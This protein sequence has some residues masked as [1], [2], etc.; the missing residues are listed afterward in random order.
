MSKLD[1]PAS[2]TSSNQKSTASK[3]GKSGGPARANK[4]TKQQ[5]SAIASK[6]AK[7]KNSK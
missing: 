2:R 5:R 3:G 1:N 7:A 6:G 4:L